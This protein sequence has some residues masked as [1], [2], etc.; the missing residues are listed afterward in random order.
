M[1]QIQQALNIKQPPCPQVEHLQEG[2]PEL[3]NSARRTIHH[4]LYSIGSGK[5]NKP[6]TGFPTQQKLQSGEGFYFIYLFIF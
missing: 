6:L 3:S 1:L 5:Y 2:T 4:H